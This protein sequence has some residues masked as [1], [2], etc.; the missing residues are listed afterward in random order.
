MTTRRML[1]V[2]VAATLLQPGSGPA[3]AMAQAPQ[4]TPRFKTGS[5][6]VI[7]DV[8]IRDRKG[9]TLR[10]VRPDVLLPKKLPQ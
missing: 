3:A 9:R 6:V 10:D 5:E 4:E 1:V 8:V 7:L 2:A